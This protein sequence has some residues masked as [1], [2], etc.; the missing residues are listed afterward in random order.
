LIL[1]GSFTAYK[2]WNSCWQSAASGQMKKVNNPLQLKK[3]VLI[4]PQ[5]QIVQW[6]PTPSKVARVLCHM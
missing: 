2:N 5:G 3:Q 4:V 1:P 6:L